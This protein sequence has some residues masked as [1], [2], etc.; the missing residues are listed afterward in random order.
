[1]GRPS[2][3]YS[4]RLTAISVCGQAGE[5]AQRSARA[6]RSSPSK[7]ECEELYMCTANARA[8]AENK[9][10]LPDSIHIQRNF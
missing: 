5:Q 8:T 9:T 1:M 10:A 4:K 6:T 2:I 3:R 7:T